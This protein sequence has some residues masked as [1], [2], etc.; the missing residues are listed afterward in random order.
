MP[1]LPMHEAW[2]Y[3]AAA[4]VVFLVV[5]VA[6]VGIVASKIGRLE[7]ELDGREAGRRAGTP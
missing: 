2:P 4:Y 5:V 6:Y 3:V 7:R 1:A